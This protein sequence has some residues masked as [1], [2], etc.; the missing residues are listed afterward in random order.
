MIAAVL[1]SA[2][3]QPEFKGCRRVVFSLCTSQVITEVV[4]T[5]NMP[6]K[7]LEKLLQTNVDEY[8]PVDMT[9]YKLVWQVIGP[10]DGDSKEL[11]VQ[12]WAVPVNMLTRYY[13]VANA[14]N[15]L[16]ERIDGDFFNVM[17]LPVL[18]LSQML[19]QFGIDLLS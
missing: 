7:R 13:Q 17:G 16:V 10:K 6:A 5:P 3:H 8:F 15:L 1:K 9:E 4:T 14:C 12:L 2:L 19:Q 11:L 18:L